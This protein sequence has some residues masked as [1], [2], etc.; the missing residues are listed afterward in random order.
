MNNPKS[1][2]GF[3]LFELIIVLAIVAI[4]AA[5]AVPSMESSITKNSVKSLQRTY[6]RAL[7]YARGEAVSRNK[8]VSIC[9]SIDG[10]AC[11]TSN[12]DWSGGW[13]IFIDDGT[14]SAYGNGQLDAG[15]ELLRVFENSGSSTVAVV[16][17]ENMSSELNSL[18]WNFRGFVDQRVLLTV[19][20]RNSSE[21]F[22]RG[23]VVE[24]SGRA[25]LT[26]DWDDDDLHESVYEDASGTL[27]YS[28]LS[29]S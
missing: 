2:S 4:L 27:T 24:R 15:E 1:I 20:G 25:M 8:L 10:L 7:S 3:T 29:C 21:N 28:D 23:V 16:D 17:L 12:H 5:V 14:A 11:D 6:L 13:L 22:A 9:P 19:C 26:Q 18:S